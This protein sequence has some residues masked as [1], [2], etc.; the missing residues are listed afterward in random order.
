MKGNCRKDG[1]RSASCKAADAA[2]PLIV[3]SF[4]A[5][6]HAVERAAHD[7]EG[8]IDFVC[9]DI[10]GGEPADDEGAGGDGEEAIGHEGFDDGHGGHAVIV[11]P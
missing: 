1:N 8:G 4:S 5:I 9:G 3:L 10:E 11:F 2:L 7:G 6:G